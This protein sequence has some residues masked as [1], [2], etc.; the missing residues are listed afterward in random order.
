[1]N[2]ITLINDFWRFYDENRDKL[3]VSDILLYKVILRYCNKTGWINPFSVNPFL[4]SEINPLSTN[5]YY[6]S[7]NSL[8]DLGLI[9]YNKGKHN[10][11]N[12]KITILKIKNS[13]TDSLNNSVDNSIKFSTT[14]SLNNSVGNNN[15]TIILLNNNTIKQLRK[16]DFDFFISTKEFKDY[17]ESKNL[18]VS[19]KESNMHK[20]KLFDEFWTSYHLICNQ[21]K[22]DRE[23]ALKRFNRL[24]V[25]EQQKAIDNIKKYYLSLSDVKYCKKARTYLADKNFNDEFSNPKKPKLTGFTITTKSII[26]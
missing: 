9:I 21:K 22:T 18:E 10:V 7:L 26:T 20:K 4:M 11:N 1:M 13:T 5:T 6:K 12:A 25:I 24:T 17:L 16:E 14:D 8:N 2:Y 15:K 23:P 3:T 19:K